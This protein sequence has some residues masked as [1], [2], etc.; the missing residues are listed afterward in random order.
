MDTFA[1][2]LVPIVL[3]QNVLSQTQSRPILEHICSYVPGISLEEQIP[4]NGLQHN[5]KKHQ[6]TGTKHIH[7]NTKHFY[8]NEWREA[9]GIVNLYL[10]GSSDSEGEEERREIR[11]RKAFLLVHKVAVE[12]LSSSNWVAA[13]NLVGIEENSYQ[14]DLRQEENI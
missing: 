7:K 8:F 3:V 5:R 2:K 4:S 9:S 14:S 10:C 12:I 11:K 13:N 6:H 1:I